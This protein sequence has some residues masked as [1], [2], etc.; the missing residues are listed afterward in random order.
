[1]ADTIELHRVRSGAAGPEGLVLSVAIARGDDRRDVE[2]WVLPLNRHLEPTVHQVATRGMSGGMA[3]SIVRGEFV[4]HLDHEAAAKW[5]K[6][7]PGL[8]WPAPMALV[9]EPEETLLRLWL[10][11]VAC[12]RLKEIHRQTGSKTLKE[13]LAAIIQLPRPTI[14]PF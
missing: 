6:Q 5:S 13:R 4:R 7:Y 3:L 1:M 12:D 11:N 14:E 2:V 10:R 9:S 8:E